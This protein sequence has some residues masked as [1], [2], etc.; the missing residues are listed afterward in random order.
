VKAEGGYVVLNTGKRL[1]VAVRK[2]ETLF[3]EIEKL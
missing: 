2:K 3:K 1:P